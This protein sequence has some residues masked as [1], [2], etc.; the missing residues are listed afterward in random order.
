M[1]DIV[2]FIHAHEHNIHD[3]LK[4]KRALESKLNEI[5]ELIYALCEHQWCDDYIENPYSE[6]ITKITYC[7][8]CECSKR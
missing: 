6:Q 3:L 2:S 8:Y 7:K 4:E 1:S 5:N